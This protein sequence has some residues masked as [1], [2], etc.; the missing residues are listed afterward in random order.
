METEKPDGHRGSRVPGFVA[1]AAVLA[2]AVGGYLYY[3]SN[4]H[5]DVS[6]ELQQKPASP[7]PSATEGTTAPASPGDTASNSSSQRTAA[8]ATPPV[9]P[10]PNQSGQTANQN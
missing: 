2:V 3:Q 9:E 10:G 8:G 6:S 5:P 4:G 7:A 1:A